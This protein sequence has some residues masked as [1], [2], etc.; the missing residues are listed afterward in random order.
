MTA[1]GRRSA[2]SSKVAAIALTPIAV[3]VVLLMPVIYLVGNPIVRARARR[4]YAELAHRLGL[5]QGRVLDRQFHVGMFVSPQMRITSLRPGP[6]PAVA[7][8]AAAALYAEGYPE[9][10]KVD[11]LPPRRVYFRPPRG[12]ELPLVAMSIYD[13]GE[14]IELID[15]QVPAGET[16]LTFSL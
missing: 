6:W 8:A 7:D 2:L 3:L 9:A 11:G 10:R 13:A 4:R 5:D 15:S 14:V 1:P 12:G 16:G